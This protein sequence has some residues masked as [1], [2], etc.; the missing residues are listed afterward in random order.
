MGYITEFIT[1][2]IVQV[3]LLSFISLFTSMWYLEMVWVPIFGNLMYFYVVYKS[4]NY[5]VIFSET[6]YQN[7][8]KMY[9]PLNQYIANQANQRYAT[10]GLS[11]EK[12]E[13]YANS[14]TE[15][16]ETHKWYLNPELNLPL[17]S[18][19]TTIPT[20]VLSQVINQQFEKNF[21]DFVNA[22]R[23]EALK[24]H[25]LDTQYNHIKI[26]ELAFMCGFNSKAAFQ[27]AFKKHTGTTPT[28][29]RKLMESEMHN[30][31]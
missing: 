25:L 17:L 18:Q 10:S 11:S 19:K 6:D 4:Y 16:F 26:E 13:E 1:V 23:V 21:F 5:G 20:H 8:K 27:R 9:A 3:L 22:Y 29:Y 12:L 14:L 24:I 2:M 28:L 7:F 15:G 31:T 30:F